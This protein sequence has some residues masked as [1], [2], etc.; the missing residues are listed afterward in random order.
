M[1]ALIMYAFVIVVA[2]SSVIYFKVQEKKQSS[3]T[4]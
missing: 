2:I 1:G 4:K 3:Q